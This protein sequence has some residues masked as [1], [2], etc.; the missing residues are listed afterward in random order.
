MAVLSLF[1]HGKKLGNLTVKD[2][3]KPEQEKFFWLAIL[4]SR[5]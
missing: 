2:N 4:K 5:E 1:E 3:V